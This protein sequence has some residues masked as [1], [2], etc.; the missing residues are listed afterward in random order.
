MVAWILAKVLVA[1]GRRTEAREMVDEIRADMVELGPQMAPYI[2]T[3]DDW[4]AE[5]F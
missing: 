1:Q 4:V 3:I 5:T 2:E